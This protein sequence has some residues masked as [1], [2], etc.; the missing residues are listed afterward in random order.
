MVTVVNSDSDTIAGERVELT[1]PRLIIAAAVNDAS[2]TAAASTAATAITGF[3]PRDF[4]FDERAPDE[5][6]APQ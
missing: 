5:L 4:F 6:R 2:A 1:V 3:L